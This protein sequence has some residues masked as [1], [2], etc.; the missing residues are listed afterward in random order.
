[1]NIGAPGSSDNQNA[2]IILDTAGLK[3][4]TD[5]VIKE[6]MTVDASEL[7]GNG[8]IDAYIYTVGH[9]NLSIREAAVSGRK[10]RL[11]P[12]DPPLVEEF[13]SKRAFLTK[14]RVNTAY[15]PGLKTQEDIYTLGIKAI[16]FTKADTPDATVTAV[17]SELIDNLDLFRRQH[18]AFAEVAFDELSRDTV[19]PLH[20]GAETVYRLYGRV[21]DP[22]FHAH[23]AWVGEEP[24]FFPYVN[25]FEA[26][27]M[28]SPP[29]YEAKLPKKIPTKVFKVYPFPQREIPEVF[30]YQDGLPCSLV[31]Q[32]KQAPLVFII[33]G[34]GARF[35]SPKMVTMQKALYQAGFHVISISSPTYLDFVV[36]ASTAMVPGHLTEDAKDLYRVMELAWQKIQ[37]DI[38]VS[39][40]HLTGYRL[41]GIQSAFVSML[42]KDK[43]VFNFKRV[44]LINPPVNLFNSVSILD[45]MLVDNVPGGLDNFDKFVQEVMNKFAEVSEKMGY[46]EF[47]TDYLYRVYKKYP[48]REDFL[49]ILIGIA[50]RMSSS[51]LIFAADVMNGG[52]YIVPNNVGMSNSTSLTPYSMVLFRTAFT[53]YFHEYFYPYFRER[54]PGLSEQELIERLSLKSIESY[55]LDTEKIGLM[56]NEDDIILAPGEIEYLRDVFGKRARIYPTGG[57]C[58]NMNH[59]VNVVDMVKFFK[60][61]G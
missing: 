4:G 37:G 33:A 3:P 5:V 22:V 49:A 26:T 38:D 12:V 18:P 15:Y 60:R 61:E 23:A 6:E 17:V 30:W 44:L 10:I 8:D 39:A 36:N 27:V 51:S 1:M 52:G 54:E 40:F 53:D 21:P 45:E 35:N 20:P 41:G 11:V 25:A 55:L 42:D 47:S 34:T 24:Y 29:A 14:T 7:L 56:T 43:K 50:F 19:V 58:G 59:P 57:H 28:E 9:P 31:R 32:K 16:L 13:T 46:V 2:L 48:F